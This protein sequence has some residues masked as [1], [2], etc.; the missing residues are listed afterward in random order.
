MPRS[1]EAWAL[2]NYL[3]R[4]F[5]ID[6]MPTQSW[7]TYWVKMLRDEQDIESENLFITVNPATL[8]KKKYVHSFWDETRPVVNKQTLIC[9]NQIDD[10]QNVRGLMFCGG[11]TG[12]GS[13][14]DSVRSA[15]VAATTRLRA[16]LP[17][18]V[19]CHEFSKVGSEPFPPLSV[20]ESIMR[21]FIEFAPFLLFL[22][23]LTLWLMSLSLLV[24]LFPSRNLRARIFRRGID[25]RNRIFAG[26]IFRRG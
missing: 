3:E 4:P 2:V 8:P 20:H 23:H 21:C 25:L 15:L 13:Y 14:E 6:T 24:F 9:Q 18:K 11:W 10:I 16:Q 5:P 22:A 17:F 12:N 1:K 19:V 26:R 7:V